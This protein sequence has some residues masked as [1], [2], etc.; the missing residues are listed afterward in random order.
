M[1]ISEGYLIPNNPYI[2]LEDLNFDWSVKD[3]E[4]FDALWREG[5]PLQEIAKILKRPQDEIAVI[6]LDRARKGK[7]A[8]R[9]FGIFGG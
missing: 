5:K 1:S 7:I 8:K 4:K 2:A 3:I 9:K 6:I